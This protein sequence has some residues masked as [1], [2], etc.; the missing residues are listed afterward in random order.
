ML[1]K[2]L[3]MCDAKAKPACSLDWNVL[4]DAI[5]DMYILFIHGVCVW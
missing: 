1:G 5:A 4:L 2:L 3:G